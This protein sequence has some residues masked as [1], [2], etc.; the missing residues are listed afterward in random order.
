VSAVAKREGGN[1]SVIWGELGNFG[2]EK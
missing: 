1:D 2:L